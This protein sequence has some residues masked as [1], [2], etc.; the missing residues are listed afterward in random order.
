MI[1][2]EKSIRRMLPL[3]VVTAV[4]A[5]CGLSYPEGVRNIISDDQ[6][7]LLEES[8]LE[9]HPGLNPPRIEGSY[10]TTTLEATFDSTE[11]YPSVY[12]YY[13]NFYDQ[14]DR[15]NSV[16][17]DYNGGN[18][19]DVATGEGAFLSGNGSE[20]SL[21][22]EARGETMG[23]EYTQVSV[24][25]GTVTE[26]GIENFQLGI[27]LIEKEGD[28]NDILLM[29]VEGRRVFVER[30]G[31]AERVPWPYASF[32]AP[33]PPADEAGPLSGR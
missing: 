16:V 26:A 12:T 2:L 18:G 23:V 5:S 14:D 25:S 27:I 13:Y 28:E 9:V 4:L 33:A 1:L 32:R 30:D 21:F 11:V 20:F 22:V 15:Q 10:R 19:S 24:Y 7:R 8:G 29:P 6:I 3:V 17:M 31:L